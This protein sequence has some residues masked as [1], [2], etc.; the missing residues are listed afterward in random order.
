MKMPQ[1]NNRG[2]RLLFRSRAGAQR[3]TGQQ[4]VALIMTLILLSI[5][6]FMAVAFLVI[7][8]GQ[9][10]A[11]TTMYEQRIAQN[12][13]LGA[14]DR[15]IAEAIG[16]IIASRNLFSYSRMVSTT[17]LVRSAAKPG[18][19]AP[20]PLSQVPAVTVAGTSG[21]F[22]R[23]ENRNGRFDQGEPVWLAVLAHPDLPPSSANLVVARY[24]YEIL[25]AGNTL[26]VNYL[27]NYRMN[28]ATDPMP[29]IGPDR[30]T[31]NQGVGT[32]E[33]NGAA[34]FADL[35]MHQWYSYSYD[36]QNVNLGVAFDDMYSILRYRYAASPSS[37]PP[38]RSVV[39]ILGAG[40]TAPL[41]TDGV[42]SY[43]STVMMG[44]MLPTDP[45][46]P[47][48]LQWPWAGSDNPNHFLT[49]QDFFSPTKTSP[50]FT[51]R[52]LTALA[53]TGDPYDR[54]TFN[55]L[56][57]QLGTDS[58]PEP[59]KLN[60]NYQNPATFTP[61]TPIEFF[62]EAA[63]LLL[64]DL[65]TG[66]EQLSITNIEIYPVNR[67]TPAVHRV[68]QV[69]ANIYDATTTN[70]FPTVFQPLFSRGMSSSGPTIYISGFQQVTDSGAVLPLAGAKWHD[71]YDGR[72]FSPGDMMYGIP[73]VVGAKKGLPNFN[74]F[75]DQIVL[76]VGRKLEFRRLPTPQAG[77]WGAIYQTN[78][79][80]MMLISNRCG[81][82]LWNSYPTV[83]PDPIR[84]LGVL[85]N[86]DVQVSL[87]N[88][89]G[90]ELIVPNH[91]SFSNNVT[92]AG[93]SIGPWLGYNPQA[94]QPSFRI[95]LRAEFFAL[96][97]SEYS[98]NDDMF[99]PLSGRFQPTPSRIPP[100]HVPHWYLKLSY[101]VR[102]ALV[103]NSDPQNVRIVDYVNLDSS[104]STVNSLATN[105]CDLTYALM[106]STQINPA[107]SRFVGSDRRAVPDGHYASLWVTNHC[108]SAP[109]D[110]PDER[111][112]SYGVFNQIRI[113]RGDISPE[114]PWTDFGGWP[115]RQHATT[116]FKSELGSPVSTSPAFY[117]CF[118]PVGVVHFNNSWQANDPLVHYTV[119]DLTDALNP[120][121]AIEAHYF[122]QNNDPMVG[123][124][125]PGGIN[126][127]Y[128]PWGTGPMT[129]INTD[130]LELK[131]VGVVS[132]S[133]RELRIG[134][135]AN[136]G[137][138][139]RVHRGT[140]W[141]T[142]YL[143][144]AAVDPG[145]WS[146]WSGHRGVDGDM[147]RPTNDWHILE[148]FTTALNEN[149]TRGRMPINQSGLAAWSA[150][151]SG[152][153][154]L[155]NGIGSY[156]STFIQPAGSYVESNKPP[157]V[158]IV[159]GINRVRSD[160]Y[161]G[162]FTRLGDILAVPELT[163]ESPY[164]A[165][166]PTYSCDEAIERI[167]QQIMSLLQCDHTPRYVIYSY[168]QTLK[169]SQN[170]MGA[171][172]V[173]SSYQVMAEAAYR[174]VVR[175]E[176]A[177]TNCTPVIESFTSLPPD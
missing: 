173:P 41:S 28:R 110:I 142:L 13:A 86:A 102:M 113:S 107:N 81:V 136:I 6:T 150:T 97:I 2:S 12:A 152:V 17:N 35:N 112:P 160:V 131:D 91:W 137:W 114:E 10:S 171:N 148:H 83:P 19:P 132:S 9:R 115:T 122:G 39:Q 134:K 108:T 60:L 90:Y 76:K 57:D 34:F 165:P 149:S 18:D 104:M 70:G 166:D 147:T 44:T 121:P 146:K 40:A 55:R 59:P 172:G 77:L 133:A 21:S 169:P 24:C 37:P 120:I 31:R 105:V 167:P 157:L 135:F 42:D 54:D 23:D 144:S 88:E 139:G 71:L 101:R 65:N 29:V 141:Q 5:I 53:N 38:L 111:Y 36:P 48:R 162:T 80:Y 161:H 154:V 117:S 20:S 177:P 56:M 73:L 46:S 95:P 75:A 7:S 8:T 170:S 45:D 27:H 156:G 25:P 89:F 109:A 138:L 124:G 145:L 30:F 123:L 153:S 163:V 79:M 140:P 47:G 155:T 103:E 4:G 143:K 174:A 69:A 100:F 72:A 11:V 68:L 15:A 43:P 49:P 16:P 64:A 33:L 74:E 116:A 87:T 50:A 99:V 26:D 51:N 66:S 106:G 176:H 168:G 151:L 52:L 1:D 93:G 175:I 98:W 82:E 125:G 118:N 129:D 130:L 119:A 61:W 14:Q 58:A 32:Y 164:F 96:P 22:Y 85:L 78:V 126:R 84:S 3:R 63:D 62:S 127:H 158:R 92:V 159:D 94:P 67:Y 128:R